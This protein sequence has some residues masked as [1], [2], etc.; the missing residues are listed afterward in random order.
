MS[1]KGQPTTPRT[2]PQRSR[3][4]DQASL[5]RSTANG[6]R[7][8]GRPRP[9]STPVNWYSFP[10]SPLVRI[11]LTPYSASEFVSMVWRRYTGPPA[12]TQPL[13]CTTPVH[14]AAPDVRIG[15]VGDICPLY[16]RDVRVGSGIQSFLSE[17][18]AVVGNFEGVLAD[19]G[20]GPI[21]LKHRPDIFEVLARL[22]PLDHW[23][24]SLANNH[25]TD[26]GQDGLDETC[27]RLDDKGIRWVGTTTRPRTSLH[28]D[29]TLTAWSHWMNR[30]DGGVLRKNPGAPAEPGFHIAYPH[31]GFEH[32]REPRPYQT[33]PPGYDLIVGHHPHLPQPLE[34]HRDTVV[35]WSLGNFLTGNPLP[36]LG[37]GALLRVGLQQRSDPGPFLTSLTYREIRLDR[38]RAQCHVRL[39]H[40]E[41]TPERTAAPASSTQR[42]RE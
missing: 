4:S 21:L 26:C 7:I 39:R 20:W 35:A 9:G 41:S 19:G 40:P 30:P 37:E 42:A 32:E 12:R 3:V 11:P 16:G 15:F 6:A 28:T 18:D 17:C 36:A 31:W 27:R 8:E 13:D 29:V 22:A 38:D 5:F 2:T 14:E 23:I 33:P 25:A 24:L 10:P 34:R 1:L